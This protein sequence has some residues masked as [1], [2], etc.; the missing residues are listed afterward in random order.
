MTELSQSRQAEDGG[1]RGPDQIRIY[2]MA[3]RLVHART[4]HKGLAT[5]SSQIQRGQVGARPRTGLRWTGPTTMT[6][7]SVFRF[8]LP[9]P[10][11]S[12]SLGP[13]PIPSHLIPSH[14][15]PSSLWETPD[16]ADGNSSSALCTRFCALQHR[17]TL[18]RHLHWYRHMH[19]HLHSH[20]HLRLS[21]T[22]TASQSSPIPISESNFILTSNRRCACACAYAP[23]C[24][25]A[26]E[27]SYSCC[28]DS[29]SRPPP[30]LTRS[31]PSYGDSTQRLVKVESSAP[32]LP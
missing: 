1:V 29:H 21:S 13:R 5:M 23:A 14:P 15:H 26:C 4:V 28:C 7:L 32:C 20:L 30:L 3:D 24:L 8:N 18:H 2:I 12:P 17:P 22:P 19:M 6:A 11:S 16:A 10:R 9:S 27:C 25:R 31:L